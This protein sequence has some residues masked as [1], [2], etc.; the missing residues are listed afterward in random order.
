VDEFQRGKLDKPVPQT[1]LV[2]TRDGTGEKLMEP[3]WVQ[4]DPLAKSDAASVGSNYLHPTQ[5]YS[6]FTAFLLALLLFAYYSMPH[7]P[8]RVFALML[9]LEGSTRFLLELI[10]VEPPVLGPMSLSMVLGLCL[11]AAGVAMWYFTT[12]PNDDLEFHPE[13]SEALP[14]PTLRIA[15]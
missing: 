10:R 14:T 5:L 3:E 15:R 4:R 2:P 6:A 12:G 9:L 11:V 7:P 13:E 8:G 1:L